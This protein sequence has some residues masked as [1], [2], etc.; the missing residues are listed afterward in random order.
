MDSNVSH[1]YKLGFGLGYKLR[2]V[3]WIVHFWLLHDMHFVWLEE[4]FMLVD[5]KINIF[6]IIPS[7][8]LYN[9]LFIKYLWISKITL[10]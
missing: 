9:V 7:I 4:Y 6:S 10:V 3:G 1:D 2:R 8:I 5:S